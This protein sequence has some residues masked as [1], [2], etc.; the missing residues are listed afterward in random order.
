[1]KKTFSVITQSLPYLVLA[2]FGVFIVWWFRVYL[3]SEAIASVDLPSQIT[4]TKQLKH[5]LLAGHLSFYDP[6][7]FT[8]WPAFQFYGFFPSLVAACFA[9]VLSFFSS[10]PVTLSTHLLLVLGAA[11]LPLSLYFAA[12]PLGRDLVADN[13]HLSVNQTWILALMCSV[14][15]FWFLNHDKQWHGIGAAAPMN[16]G[17]FSQIFGWHFF[18]LH[19]G[20]LLRYVQTGARL[21]AVCL[22]LSYGLLLISHTLTFVFSS[23]LV[24]FSWGWFHERRLGLL[25]AHLI[26]V[27]LVAFWFVP[28]VSFM[29]EYTSYSI[30]RPKGDFLELFFRYPL[31]GLLR[32][33]RTW[34]D[35]DF[36][37]LNPINS[38]NALL[39]FTL[40]FH[41][42]IVKT[43]LLWV[44]VV[45]L[46]LALLVFSSGFVATSLPIGLHY[47]RFLGYC[48]IL[49]TLIICVI[50]LV[51]LRQDVNYATVTIT[52]I[53]ITC[54]GITISL[55]HE[56][57]ELIQNNSSNTH[58]A[59]QNQVLDYFKALPAKGR[60]YVEFIKDGKKFTPLAK[61]NI[62]SRL[63]QHSGFESVVNSHLQETV[64]YRMIVASVNMLGAKTYNSA[65]LFK[66]HATLDDRANIELL[67]SFGITHLVAGHKQFYRR[68]K[69]FAITEPVN[70]GGYR[71]VQ[72]QQLP[73]EKIAAVDKPVIGFL[74]LKDNLPFH[75]LEFYFYSR[76]QLSSHFEL[77]RIDHKST[78]PSGLSGLLV[79]HNEDEIQLDNQ[80]KMTDHRV[81]EINFSRPYLLNHYKPH[82]PHNVEID[83]YHEVE[84][85]LDNV[86]KLPGLFTSTFGKLSAIDIANMKTPSLSWSDDK[87]TMYLDGLEPG[88]MYRINYSY[89][90]YWRSRDE[91][92]LRGSGERMFYMAEHHSATLEYQKQGFA[93]TTLGYL[94]TL[95]AWGLIA[96]KVKARKSV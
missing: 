70:I 50:P 25:T 90:P 30:I 34:L 95:I 86:V 74:D 24:L 49:A 66:K 45:F 23:F 92:V 2:G 82:Y 35:G 48:F 20:I 31:Y 64:T 88:K 43:G 7:T 76:K 58:L 14:W 57:R 78:I 73:S 79:N 91:N 28:F 40:F 33:I 38:I 8:G 89:F 12:L 11:L 41:R 63:Y 55:P 26:G 65:L 56:K 39:F 6:T 72:I 18:L 29:G 47:Y 93:S 5:Q 71:I 75:L 42:K 51:F 22:S 27:G 62:A 61:H 37:L 94:I 67:K 32:S 1:M 59:V 9:L 85:Y 81:I 46:L 77:I 54:F 84:K 3:T 44:M 10:D 13:H 87:Q 80:R 21:F 60:V 52:L 83:A 96:M 15:S 17:L 19:L 16:I 68:I 4:L 36:K 53:A 69:Q